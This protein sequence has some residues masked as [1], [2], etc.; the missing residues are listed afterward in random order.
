MFRNRESKSFRKMMLGILGGIFYSVSIGISAQTIQLTDGKFSNNLL[1]GDT[2][3]ETGLYPLMLGTLSWHY[4]AF[5]G[6]ENVFYYGELDN[7]TARDGQQSLKLQA[8]NSSWSC[9]AP[10]ILESG[11]TYTFSFYAKA[12]KPSSGAIG[13]QQIAWKHREEKKI[14]FTTEWKRYSM[15]IKAKG[16]LYFPMVCSLDSEIVWID[17]LQLEKEKTP[18][19]YKTGEAVTVNINFTP[20]PKRIFFPDDK[21]KSKFIVRNTQTASP[22]QK[23][24][25]KYT[26]IDFYGKIVKKEKIPVSFNDKNIFAKEV[27][28][29]ANALGTF[30]IHYQ[31]EADNKPVTNKAFDTYA[32]IPPP[33]KINDGME[34]FCGYDVRETTLDN[35]KT[36]GV[37]W[38]QIMPMWQF[39][40]KEKEKFDWK[41]MDETISSLK[42]NGFLVK[43]VFAIGRGTPTWAAEPLDENAGNVKF[44]MPANLEA[45][46]NFIHQFT[47]RYSDKIDLYEIGAEDD[48]GIGDNPYYR[49]KYP[50]DV[51]GKFICSGPV[52]DKYIEMIKTASEEIRKINPNAKIGAI[53]PS[54]V[55]CHLGFPFSSVIFERAGKSFNMFPMDPYTGPRLIGAGRIE[56]RDPEYLD[57]IFKDAGELAAKYGNQK[58]Y[59]AELAWYHD[60]SE[61]FMTESAEKCTRKIIRSC[62]LS[63]IAPNVVYW[64]QMGGGGYYCQYTDHLC[65]W[66][67][68]PTMLV[69]VYSMTARMIENVSAV[70]EIKLN[71]RVK[72]AVFEKD[73][74]AVAVIWAT[75]N[76]KKVL[77]IS[78]LKDLIVLD[79]IGNPQK[80]Q[81]ED[82][83]LSIPFDGWPVYLLLHGNEAAA[84]L[85][86]A[87][88][89]GKLRSIPVVMRSR[90]SS[91]NH[92]EVF[93]ENLTDN[94]LKGKI[95]IFVGDQSPLG[96]NTSIPVAESRIFQFPINTEL[97]KTQ[98]IKVETDFPGED[99]VTAEFTLEPLIK[100]MK[101]KNPVSIDGDM[102]KWKNHPFILMNDRLQVEP[103]DP[104]VPWPG[105][106]RFSAKVYTGWDE[107]ALYI[108]AEVTDYRHFNNQQK[109][110]IYNGDSMQLAFDFGNDATFRAEPGYDANDKDFMIALTSSGILSN[111]LPEK[112]KLDIVRKGDKTCYEVS[113]PKEELP[114]GFALSPGTVFGFNF[115]IFNDNDGAGQSHHYYLSRGITEGKDPRLFRKII[116]SE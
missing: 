108:A 78:S 68:Y 112:S 6:I 45:W 84:K 23:I 81:K 111:R 52:M 82:N 107:K 47:K 24:N 74:C 31:L 48:L 114:G 41:E 72:S 39:M 20:E 5:A 59:V 26:V 110:T 57:A 77:E 63:R 40:E 11:E 76:D 96:L 83:K 90:I 37:K 36:I 89:Q 32:I 49:K 91:A 92:G 94:R 14:S 64:H 3:F 102:G 98:R 42:Q 53:R 80:T 66:G 18:T 87:I 104:Q 19:A 100:C 88:S 60:I 28:L 34:A 29:P 105:P 86:L 73:D 46:R 44:I 99:K 1:P 33:V 62:L 113:I 101:V 25:I 115:V 79:V 61:A 116:L 38:T 4:G 109:N 69:P 97:K 13:L 55:D 9:G 93:V 17:C 50:Q 95:N 8:P 22:A 54:D 75:D 30:L 103:A 51:K 106:E 27:A 7:T 58:L 16:K 35:L 67:F 56:T 71:P 21:I 15:T 65:L 12:K 70:K 10:V 85:S 2:S 43:A